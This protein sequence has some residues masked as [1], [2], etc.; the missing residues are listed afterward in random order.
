MDR[1]IFTEAFSAAGSPLYFCSVCAKPFDQGITRHIFPPHRLQACLIS[2]LQSHR[3]FPH[4]PPA[5]LPPTRGEE[6]VIAPESMPFMQ[7]DEEQMR[8]CAA[9]LPVR[10]EGAGVFLRYLPQRDDIRA[11]YLQCDY[12]AVEF[13]CRYPGPYNGHLA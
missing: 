5:V 7:E 13:W 1:H 10:W 4:P 12:S 6:P 3:N 11:R 2:D 9:L 8:L